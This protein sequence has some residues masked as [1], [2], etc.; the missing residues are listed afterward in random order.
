MRTDRERKPEQL[1]RYAGQHESDA[2]TGRWQQCDRGNHN[3]PS[4]NQQ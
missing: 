4:R 3:R 1:Y 2:R